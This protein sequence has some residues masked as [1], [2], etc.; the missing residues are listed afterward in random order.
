M[1]VVLVVLVVVDA[2]IMRSARSLPP[3]VAGV[4]DTL[5]RSPTSMSV[6]NKFAAETMKVRCPLGVLMTIVS[7]VLETT[8]PVTVVV[9]VVVDVPVAG[10]SYV[11]VAGVSPIAMTIVSALLRAPAVVVGI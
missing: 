3:A 10:R 4:N 6:G 9:E 7:A 2:S 11:E 8:V 1:L 5:T